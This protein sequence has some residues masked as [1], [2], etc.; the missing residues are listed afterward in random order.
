[1]YC[2]ILCGW[3]RRSIV[4]MSG[5]LPQYPMSKSGIVMGNAPSP[6]FILLWRVLQKHI[7]SAGL[8]NS[9]SKNMYSLMYSLIILFLTWT[10]QNQKGFALSKLVGKI[11]NSYNSGQ[12]QLSTSVCY[13]TNLQLIK[14][15]T[16]VPYREYS[17]FFCKNICGKVLTKKTLIK[18]RCSILSFQNS[19]L[20][21][22][23]EN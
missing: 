17:C 19:S 15:F 13:F 23:T 9:K 14:K 10:S 11:F 5:Y 21:L 3:Q 2:K 16:W 7:Y 6:K 22:Q 1:M 12:L 20:F 8:M 18:K 4:K